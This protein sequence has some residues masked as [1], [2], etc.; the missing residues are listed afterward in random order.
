VRGDLEHMAKTNLRLTRSKLHLCS[1]KAELLRKGS[2]RGKYAMQQSSD[3]LQEEE[4]EHAG[5]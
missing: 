2:I 4:E 1:Y 5:V 3:T